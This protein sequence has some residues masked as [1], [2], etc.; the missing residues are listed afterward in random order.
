MK[1]E[2]D[3]VM[4]QPGVT[5]VVCADADGL[6]ICAYGNTSRAS[7]A[8]ISAVASQAA[9]LR[10]AVNGPSGSSSSPVVVIETDAGQTMI[11][12]HA[13]ITTAIYKSG[14]SRRDVNAITASV[15]DL[16]R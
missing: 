16:P 3:D 12:S 11:K 1:K 14:P 9:A 10:P 7:A 4:L 5:G 2:I 13:G 6:C 15:V 8:L